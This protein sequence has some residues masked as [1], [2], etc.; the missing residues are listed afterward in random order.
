M[1]SLGEYTTEQLL[2]ELR[3]RQKHGFPVLNKPKRKIYCE[4]CNGYTH[5]ID[6]CPYP[7]KKQYVKAQ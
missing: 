2:E 5:I 7:R 6:E 3:R 4:N 1:S